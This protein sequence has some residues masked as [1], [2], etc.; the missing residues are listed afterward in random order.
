MFV[1]EMEGWIADAGIA[2]EYER[3]IEIRFDEDDAA[4]KYPQHVELTVRRS[5]Y[6][7][8]PEDLAEN[9]K[10]KVSVFPVTKKGVSKAGKPYAIT[11]LVVNKFEVT[12]KAPKAEASAPQ[13]GEIEDEELPF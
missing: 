9:D 5:K 3:R 7:L 1:S 10:I 12:K 11:E 6:D 4:V 2:G 8:I 13:D